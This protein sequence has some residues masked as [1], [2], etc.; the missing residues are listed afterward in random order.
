[1][2]GISSA[3][4]TPK[5]QLDTYLFE[6][7]IDAMEHRVRESGLPNK[8]FPFVAA[9]CVAHPEWNTLGENPN[10]YDAVCVLR[11]LRPIA[12]LP[13]NDLNRT[14]PFNDYLLRAIESKS[15]FVVRESPGSRDYIVGSKERVDAVLNIISERIASGTFSETYHRKIGK[16][17]GYP[18]DAIEAFIRTVSQGGQALDASIIEATCPANEESILQVRLPNGQT[19]FVR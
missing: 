14:H 3:L 15:G 11:D 12:L 10:R 2:P 4:I 9:H 7:R 5:I 16:A 13:T 6:Q 8:F 19:V 17:L 18:A 1:M